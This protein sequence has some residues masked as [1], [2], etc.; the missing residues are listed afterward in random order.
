MYNTAIQP[1]KYFGAQPSF[2]GGLQ[3]K[4]RE[5][6]KAREL[7]TEEFLNLFDKKESLKMAYI[8]HFMTLC[9]V[10]Y[11]EQLTQYANGYKV[12][13]LKRPARVLNSVREEHECALKREMP[14]AV[15]EQF[16]RQREE[17]LASCGANLLLAVY[18]TN[19]QL[20]KAH[21]DLKGHDLMYCYALIMVAIIKYVE[22]FDRSVNEKI[23]KKLGQPC[24]N[25]GD[26]RLSLIKKVC[27]GV[28][29]KFYVEPNEEINL[30]VKIMA[31]K[32]Q[33]MINE[34]L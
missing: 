25:S 24:R 22:A 4:K 9:I 16:C 18:T 20:L 26:E 31:N 21:G 3:I 17:Y 5:P 14:P 8:P 1:P 13:Q 15:Y 19:N 2:Y 33:A 34:M 10:Y 28:L 12:S 23:A 27:L 6:K 29:G 32:A 7:S 11:I 30:C